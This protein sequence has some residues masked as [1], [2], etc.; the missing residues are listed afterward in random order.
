MLV[1]RK[2]K[3][4]WDNLVYFGIMVAIIKYAFASTRFVLP[5]WC[6]ILLMLIAI[7][8]FIL[9]IVLVRISKKR[10]FIFVASVVVA[11]MVYSCNG[12]DD[13]LLI[14]ILAF[15][16]LKDINIDKLI[17]YY[18]V[19]MLSFFVLVVGHSLLTGENIGVYA[20]FRLER[21]YEYRYTFGFIHPNSLQGIYM[22]TAYGLILSKWGQHKKKIKYIMLEIVNIVL[23]AF[24]D[25]RT[26]LIAM[27]AVL[28]MVF[29]AEDVI[30]IF[31]RKTFL[32]IMSTMGLGIIIFT[33]IASV[34]YKK[35]SLLMWISALIN[36]RFDFANRFLSRY[37][38]RLFGTDIDEYAQVLALD[39][40]IMNTLLHYGILV[41]IASVILYMLGI[42]RMWESGYYVG[43]A[44]TVGYIMYSVLE[45]IYFN[46]FM[47]LGIVLCFYI[48]INTGNKF[49]NNGDK[50]RRTCGTIGVRQMSG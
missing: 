30:K 12:H 35:S 33:V 18:A 24:S 23:F 46:P 27:T 49:D 26:G 5:H 17:N 21:G 45:N 25:S 6:D 29:F 13:D 22:R 9:H 2:M 36:G 48:V 39:C 47:N 16:A 7:S 10:F 3:L 50:S 40:G 14:F 37:P 43:M 20:G 41:F 1:N 38:V 11:L 31:G 28:I 4:K 34:F 8:C 15:F 19:I 44:V 32:Y 42:R